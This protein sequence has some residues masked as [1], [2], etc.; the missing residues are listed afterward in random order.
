MTEHQEQVLAPGVAPQGKETANGERL[1]HTPEGTPAPAAGAEV[2]QAPAASSEANGI[3]ATNRHAA[4]GR[5]GARRYHQLIQEGRLY[6]KEHGL[7]RGRQRLRQLIELGKAYE[8]E[9]GLRPSRRQG[10]GERLARMGREEVL[11]TLLRCLVRIA[12]PSFREDLVR[13]VEALA[14]DENGPAA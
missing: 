6:E 14:K 7:K 1:P 9:H 5:K 11:E 10:R 12:K 3:A 8:Q 4:A 13:L 2:A